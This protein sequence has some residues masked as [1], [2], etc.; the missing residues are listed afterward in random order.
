MDN[1]CPMTP[2]D[3]VRERIQNEGG[4]EADIVKPRHFIYLARLC[5]DPLV[6]QVAGLPK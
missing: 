1:Q 4:A 3:V 2:T 6:S 5:E